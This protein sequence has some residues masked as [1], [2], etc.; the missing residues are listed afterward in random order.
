M[1][2]KKKKGFYLF[3]LERR[4]GE[5]E[6]EKHQGVRD[7]SFSCVSQAPNRGLALQARSLTGNPTSNPLLPSPAINPLS[8]TSQ[9][10][11][12]SCKYK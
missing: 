9:G 10:Y 5:R 6:G 11:R 2:K 12:K 3:T 1:L 8:Q 4:E 7:T